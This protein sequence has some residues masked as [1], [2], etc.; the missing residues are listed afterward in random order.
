MTESSRGQWLCSAAMV[1][2]GSTVVASRVIGQD[3]EPFLATALRHAAALPVFLLLMVATGARFERVGWRD[4]ADHRTHCLDRRRI[5][6]QFRLG[7]HLCT[8]AAIL[9]GDS[10]LSQ[11]PAHVQTHF[12]DVER[13]LEVVDRTVTHRLDR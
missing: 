3:V 11:R 12:F 4:A 9:F 13:L 7:A 5:A 8:K 1:L 10:L 2:V 6:C